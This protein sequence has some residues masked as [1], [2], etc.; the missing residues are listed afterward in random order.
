ML[1]AVT[2]KARSRSRPVNIAPNAARAQAVIG[3]ENSPVPNATST[4]PVT[5]QL[6]WTPSASVAVPA[7]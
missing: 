5:V 3:G 7:K 6:R 1:E 2:M 4:S